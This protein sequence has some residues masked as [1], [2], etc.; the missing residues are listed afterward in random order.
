MG[1]EDIKLVQ[2][3]GSVTGYITA[4]GTE[5]TMDDYDPNMGL[6]PWGVDYG[7]CV[8]IG[9]DGP[10]RVG[11]LTH[12]YNTTWSGFYFGLE[13]EKQMTFSDKLRFYFQISLPKYSSEGIWPNRTDWQQNPSF[14]D[15]GSNG[16]Y[17]YSAEMEYNLRLSSRL[18]LAVKV[19]M[20]TFH[21]GNIPGE[22]YVASYSEFLLD[23]N[24]Q[25]V[26]DDNGLPILETTPAH[27]EYVSDSLEHATWRSFGIQL[28][29]KYAF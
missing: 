2:Q 22:L 13:I 14:L 17:A 11:G 26:L 29:L 20:N 18:G 19:D 9:G 28:N 5:L 16:A 21:V 27:T 3:A 15:E 8:I 25:Y 12:I 6:I 23:E 7:E 10:I 4:L 24:G 1:P